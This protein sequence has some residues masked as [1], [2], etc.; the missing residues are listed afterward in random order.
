MDSAPGGALD[1]QFEEEAF[2]CQENVQGLDEGTSSQY[3]QLIAFSSRIRRYA[4]YR[5]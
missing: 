5:I 1:L 2:F 4:L 3:A